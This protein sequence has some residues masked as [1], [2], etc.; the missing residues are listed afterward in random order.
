MRIDSDP[1]KSAAPLLFRMATPRISSP[2]IPG[3]YDP[4]LQVWAIEAGRVKRPIVEVGD[5]ELVEITTKT[6]VR[7]EVNDEEITIESCAARVAP[8]GYLTELVTKTEVQ[9]E[10]DDEEIT[11][12][13]SGDHFIP[14]RDLAELVTKTDVQQESDD[15][16]DAIG[17]VE[18]DTKT[19]VQQEQDDE[20]IGRPLLELETKTYAG[21]KYDDQSP[22]LV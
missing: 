2:D 1:A 11:D 5:A 8:L 14:R 7:H 19:A 12:Q 21:V 16:I 13:V 4:A 10:S 6:K 15:Q 17:L 9:H 3:A 18:L 20:C 22:M